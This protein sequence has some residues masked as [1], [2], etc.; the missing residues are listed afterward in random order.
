MIVVV[1]LSAPNSAVVIVLFPRTC[2]WN[3]LGRFINPQT[4]ISSFLFLGFDG[5]EQS[6]AP[7]DQLAQCS[8]LT[9]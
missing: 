9:P 1:L 2:I 4:S 3:S 8:L 5:G 7:L 6:G